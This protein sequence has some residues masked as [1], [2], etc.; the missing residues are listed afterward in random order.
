[1]SSKPSIETYE[2]SDLKCPFCND[3][4]LYV[5]N[6]ESTWYTMCLMCRACGPVEDSAEE[7]MDSWC[8][9]PTDDDVEALISRARR[10][11][12]FS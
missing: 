11:V 12:F 10:Q 1:M 8:T 7:A 5:M 6:D 4:E 9:R 3:A 2:L